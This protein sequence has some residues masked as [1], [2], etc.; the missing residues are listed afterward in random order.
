MNAIAEQTITP[1]TPLAT[2]QFLDYFALAYHQVVAERLRV[3][4]EVVLRRANENLARWLAQGEFSGAM[5]RPLQEWQNLLAESDVERIIAIITDDSDEGQRLRQS[6]PFVGILTA[7]ERKELLAT[8]EKRA[9]A[10]TG[11]ACD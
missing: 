10:Q 6:T 11:S 3:A 5:R 9:S 1:T 4:P 7:D 8:C 2:H